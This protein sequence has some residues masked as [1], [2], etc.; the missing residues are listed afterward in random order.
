MNDTLTTSPTNIKGFSKF[1]TRSPLELQAGECVATGRNPDR[2]SI[3]S[4]LR[5]KT[6]THEV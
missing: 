2:A 4:G 1:V 5:A 6:K 3:G